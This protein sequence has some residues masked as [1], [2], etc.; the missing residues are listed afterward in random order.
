MIYGASPI[1]GVLS[2]AATHTTTRVGVKAAIARVAETAAQAPAAL[3]GV[4]A[5]V[6]VLVGVTPTPGNRAGVVGAIANI[7]GTRLTALPPT[8]RTHTTSLAIV[9]TDSRALTILAVHTA[10]MSAS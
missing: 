9:D 7:S 4:K 5:S 1:L 10:A 2:G 6:A 3:V 8:S